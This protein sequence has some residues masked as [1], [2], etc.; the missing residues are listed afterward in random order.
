LFINRRS[1]NKIVVHWCPPGCR[2]QNPVLP[3]TNFTTVIYDAKNFNYLS[4]PFPVIVVKAIP[5]GKSSPG[6]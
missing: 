6:I 3:S 5:V 2:G 4:L 1:G